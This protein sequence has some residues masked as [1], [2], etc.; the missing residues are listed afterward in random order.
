MSDYYVGM[1]HENFLANN[2]DNI[3]NTDRV[4]DCEGGNVSQ[5]QWNDGR[6]I[7]ILWQSRLNQ[8][9]IM[10]IEEQKRVNPL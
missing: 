5:Y 6:I 4:F 7:L 1:K 2:R 3:R 10:Y 9:R 8:L